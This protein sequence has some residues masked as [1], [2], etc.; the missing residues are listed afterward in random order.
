M[1]RRYLIFTLVI[2]LLLS[3]PGAADDWGSSHNLLLKHDFSEEWFMI[4]RSNLAYRDNNEELFLGYTGAS[5]GYQWNREWSTRLGYRVARFKIG[6]EW[7]TEQR[8]MA[9][10][11]YASILDGWRFSS[12][13]RAEFRRPDW[14]EKDVRFRQELT[15]T[16]PWKMTRLGIKPFLE[17]EIFYSSR[18]NQIEAN[19]ITLGLSFFPVKGLKLKAGY[20][21]NRLRV[22]GEFITRHT[23]MTGLNLFF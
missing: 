17:E 19:W 9:E 2:L 8:P 23:L 7:R 10:I 5:L 11:Y 16:A 1:T 21:H 13:S 6:E 20:R 18:A 12:R 22:M 4:S 14:T 15:V 3:D